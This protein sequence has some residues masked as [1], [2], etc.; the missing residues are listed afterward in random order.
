MKNTTFED[1]AK[2]SSNFKK[3]QCQKIQRFNNSTRK[4][5]KIMITEDSYARNC[6]AELHI[7]YV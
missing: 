5:H 2:F 3:R 1:R 6:A 7:I 4:K